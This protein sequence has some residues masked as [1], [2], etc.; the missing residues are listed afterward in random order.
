VK[1][2]WVLEIGSTKNGRKGTRACAGRGL[3]KK[4]EKC[5]GGKR[6][7]G[8]Q[9]LHSVR[10]ERAGRGRGRGLVKP[11]ESVK[12]YRRGGGKAAWE[13]KKGCFEKKDAI[14]YNCESQ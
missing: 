5:W 9:R 1:S 2:K 10:R 12:V 3:A 11:S 4:R 6:K 8:P 7:S 13:R 14:A